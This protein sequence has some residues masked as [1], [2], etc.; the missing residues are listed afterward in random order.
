M[1][2]PEARGR[3]RFSHVGHIRYAY[4]AETGLGAVPFL[5][6][7]E[8]DLLIAEALIR[9]G[10]SRT[11]AA[12]LINRTRV[13]RGGLPALIG[14]EPT[15]QLFDPLFYER[16]VEL[17]A[18]AMNAPYYDA[19]RTDRLQPLTPRQMPVPAN[20]LDLRGEPIYTFGG[21]EYPDRSP[22]STAIGRSC[23]PW[24]VP[25][26]RFRGGVLEANLNLFER[27]AAARRAA[28][29]ARQRRPAGDS[30]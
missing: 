13:G 15:Q 7:A 5:L 29:S 8:N 26:V 11:E 16:D 2:W 3:Y 4:H 21:P 22:P 24:D 10:G 27:V 14:N 6:A 18:P 12:A 20:E 28:M 30:Y 23:T 1:P 9:T 25:R 19:R 17:Y